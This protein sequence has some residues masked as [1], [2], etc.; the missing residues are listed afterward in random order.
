MTTAAFPTLSAQ[1]RRQTAARVGR[2][3]PLQA[4]NRSPTGLK[5]E[6]SIASLR[7]GSP[8]EPHAAPRVR[9]DEPPCLGWSKAAPRATEPHRNQ[10][11]LLVEIPTRRNPRP[12]SSDR[13]PKPDQTA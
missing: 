4:V 7:T 5:L 6:A 12:C 2:K 3:A 13:L 10:R 9:S 1:T 8:P 11:S